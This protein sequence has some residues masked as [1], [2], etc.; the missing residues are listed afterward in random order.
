[1]LWLGDWADVQGCS[2]S[3]TVHL[4]FFV[5]RQLVYCPLSQYIL[6]LMEL[7]GLGEPSGYANWLAFWP[8]SGKDADLSESFFL[9]S[10]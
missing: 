1:M 3:F 4:A 8:L 7:N 2:C 6:F 5:L 10:F 9:S